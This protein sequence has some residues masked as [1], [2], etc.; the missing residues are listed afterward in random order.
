MIIMELDD[1]DVV[2]VVWIFIKINHEIGWSVHV[3]KGDARDT[4]SDEVNK[5]A[6]LS[7][8]KLK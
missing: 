7:A 8:W 3:D 6:C 2:D 4:I 1:R 5:Q